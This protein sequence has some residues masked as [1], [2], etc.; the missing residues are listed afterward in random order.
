MC[1]YKYKYFNSEHQVNLTDSHEQCQLQHTIILNSSLF[2]TLI[3]TEFPYACLHCFYSIPYTSRR[4]ELVPGHD[5]G[6][7]IHASQ[8]R[9]IC[10]LTIMFSV[11]DIL[12]FSRGM[13]VCNNN[14][15]SSPIYYYIPQPFIYILKSNICVCTYDS[16]TS[17]ISVCSPAVALV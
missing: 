1:Y 12:H 9:L 11:K 5:Y 15:C 8:Q 16:K 14:R 3:G 17:H 7:Y 2:A 13:I 4:T 6:S 10:L